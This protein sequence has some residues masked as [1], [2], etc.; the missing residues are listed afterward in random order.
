M[1]SCFDLLPA[2]ERRASNFMIR[3]V[4]SHGWAEPL[5]TGMERASMRKVRIHLGGSEITLRDQRLILLFCALRR[6]SNRR[7]NPASR[8][9]LA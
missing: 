3:K 9:V 5:R 7:L 4:M 8:F 1:L 6:A 2:G